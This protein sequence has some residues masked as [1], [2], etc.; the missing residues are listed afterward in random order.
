MMPPFL[1]SPYTPHR[2]SVTS[3]L[4][5]AGQLQTPQ[6]VA[7]LQHFAQQ[8]QQ[9]CAERMALLQS[10]V[11]SSPDRSVSHPNKS[12]EESTSSDGAGASSSVLFNTDEPP[13]HYMC[14]L[15]HA[16]NSLED[17]SSS[18]F[19]GFDFSDLD[20]ADST[21]H[22]FILSDDVT[23]QSDADQV[24]AM[25]PAAE[26]EVSAVS[27]EGDSTPG[28]NTKSHDM[29]SEEHGARTGVGS[30]PDVV[31][32]SDSHKTS[33]P[34]IG[35]NLKADSDQTEPC[36]S[37]TISALKTKRP[38]ACKRLFA[39][40]QQDSGGDR[41][42]ELC[43]HIKLKTSLRKRV[44]P[45]RLHPLPHQSGQMPKPWKSPA[46][47]IVMG[48]MAATGDEAMSLRAP[49]FPMKVTVALNKPVAEDNVQPMHVDK[50]PHGSGTSVTRYGPMSLPD[51]FHSPS[52][53]GLYW[54]ECD[55]VSP[56][57]DGLTEEELKELQ[58]NLFSSDDESFVVDDEEPSK[59]MEDEGD[60]EGVLVEGHPERL[61]RGI[62]KHECSSIMGPNSS[63]DDPLSL[64]KD[65][66]C[67]HATEEDMEGIKKIADELQQGLA[68][69]IQVE[70][71]AISEA[72]HSA[73]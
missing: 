38:C 2:S 56:T 23:F 36:S 66:G 32:L 71:Q 68:S 47:D 27:S 55:I 16:T 19:S 65:F 45:K 61:S 40:S 34:Y 42:S 21:F 20:E 67:K 7:Q 69:C 28:I 17:L 5:L 41:K 43:S 53:P 35:H 70:Q 54:N 59:S 15:E 60:G 57:F 3:A 14:S 29:C 33:T 62:V 51:V 25:S 39:S 73:V 64:S 30:S 18:L 10:P 52:D 63:D 11:A 22:S 37:W 72:A 26:V 48:E 24:I 49:G 46:Q 6:Q 8:L 50:Q 31:K 58:K 9:E 1:Q 44:A 13:S 4:G 12:T